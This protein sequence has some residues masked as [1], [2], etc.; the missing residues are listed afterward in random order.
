MLVRD[1]A[2]RD[3]RRFRRRVALELLSTTEAA[4]PTLPD[5]GELITDL[6]QILGAARYLEVLRELIH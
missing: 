2:Q 1:D 5:G 4:G 3:L 6:R